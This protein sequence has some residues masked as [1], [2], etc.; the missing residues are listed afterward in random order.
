MPPLPRLFFTQSF[1]W[2]L[3]TLIWGLLNLFY[4][5][6]LFRLFLAISGAFLGARLA[7]TYFP[8]ATTL[9]HLIII[10]LAAVITMILAYALYSFTFVLLGAL[11]GL[12]VA[13]TLIHLFPLLAP[14][15]L[16]VIVLGV[17]L[18]AAFGSALKDLVIVLATSA[19][20][21]SLTVQGIELLLPYTPTL[22]FI[23]PGFLGI[24]WAVLFIVGLLSQLNHRSL[25]A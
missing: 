6:R 8:H 17:L 23:K 9:V 12:M 15:S 5:Y 24:L 16:V 13:L 7:Q 2:A 22:S 10:L 3:V 1:T 11:A 14:F 18:G 20:G 19:G 21:A 25:P 4:G